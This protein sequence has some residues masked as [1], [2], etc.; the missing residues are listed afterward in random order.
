MQH[1]IV[2]IPLAGRHSLYQCVCDCMNL[3]VFTEGN[4]WQ[5]Y[6]CEQYV[7]AT[8]QVKLIAPDTLIVN[9]NRGLF[10][11]KSTAFI[12]FPLCGFDMTRFSTNI[13][14]YDLLAVIDHKGDHFNV[15]HYTLSVKYEQSWY[16]FDDMQ[17]VPI[18]EIDVG[19]EDAYVLVY[20]S[21]R[22]TDSTLFQPSWL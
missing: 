7:R 6:C 22:T 8:K 21:R 1:L 19:T 20:M 12:E 5:C 11:I 15:G 10:G 3:E 2:Q 4:E 18:R 16:Q 9:L 13:A 17:V 14:V